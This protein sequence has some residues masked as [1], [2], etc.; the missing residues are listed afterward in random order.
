MRQEPDAALPVR[1]SLKVSY[2]FSTV[3]AIMMAASSVMG[4]SYRAASYPSE[5][6]RSAF[7]TNDVVTLIIALPVLL[8]AMWLARR[9]SLVGLLFWP[10]ALLY[11]LYNDLIYVLAMPLNVA[12]LL[13]LALVV[14]VIFTIVR[15]FVSIDKVAVGDHLAGAVPERI[16]G[17]IL[18][19]LGAAIVLRA[20]GVMVAAIVNQNQVAET[21]LA[22]HTAD[23]LIAPVW[24]IGGVQLWRR[25]P[26]GYAIALGLLVQASMLFG[27]LILL[28]LLQPLFNESPLVLA[29]V[30]VIA[31]VGL[32]CF[33][34][35]GSTVRSVVSKRVVG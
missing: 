19:G 10:G 4:L 7:V 30:V 21:T 8:G 26:L 33:I 27:A 3:I 17:G 25:E 20:F 2:A 5:G 24:V 22:L 31:V 34:P 14:S 6:L 29:D 9:G 32:I 28:L 23:F 18:A 13:H 15:L 1:H 16:I 11:T 12:Y 35:L